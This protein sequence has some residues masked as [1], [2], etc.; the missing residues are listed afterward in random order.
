MYAL[1]LVLEMFVRVLSVCV[2]VLSATV[3]YSAEDAHKTV[4]ILQNVQNITDV[5][6]DTHSVATCLLCA[7][8]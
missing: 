4:Y 7:V 5:V 3:R 6:S 8:N 1:I 2:Y